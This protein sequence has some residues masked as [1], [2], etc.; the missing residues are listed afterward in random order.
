M[1]AFRFDILLRRFAG[2]L[3]PILSRLWIC[4]WLAM[5]AGGNVQPAEDAH[6]GY[7]TQIEII[8]ENATPS[9]REI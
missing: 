9:V 1:P 7:G 6:V 5:A 3:W 4:V 2:T 8:F